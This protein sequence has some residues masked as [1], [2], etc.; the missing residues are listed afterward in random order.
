MNGLRLIG[1]YSGSLGIVSYYG[2]EKR[3]V[4]VE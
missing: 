4:E 2:G 3:L 1:L